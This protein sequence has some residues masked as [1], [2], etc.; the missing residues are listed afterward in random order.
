MSVETLIVKYCAKDGAKN[1]KMFT[2]HVQA[3]ESPY[4]NTYI[5]LNMIKP[6]ATRSEIMGR[7][8][9]A[10]VPSMKITM[11]GSGKSEVREALTRGGRRGRVF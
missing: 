5:G 8:N 9:R 1:Y 10:E 7:V 2:F 4:C 3:M 6:G 11:V